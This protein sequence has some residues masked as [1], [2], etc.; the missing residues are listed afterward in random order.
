MTATPASGPRYHALDALR[1]TM[2]LLGIYLHAAVAYA[3]DGGW[4]WKQ[5]DL[6][7]LLEPSMA[8]IHVFRMPLFYVMAGFFAA[9]LVERR[10]AGKAAANRAWRILLPFVLGWAVVFPMVALLVLIGRVGVAGGFERFATGRFFAYAA[11]LHLWFLEYL[12]VLYAL[13]GL[14]LPLARL[15]PAGVRHPAN[16]IFRA[17]TAAWWG[18][19][20]LAVPSFLAL[21]A[22]PRAELQDP[23]GFMPVGHIVVAYAIPFAFGWMLYGNADLLDTIRRRGW[24][25]LAAALVPLVL[26]LGFIHLP[27]PGHWFFY[28]RRIEHSLALWLLVFGTTGVFLRVV[29]RHD[30]R[31]RYLC[32]SSYFLY[33]A[34]MPVLLALQLAL[35]AL[36]LH[37]AIKAM[38]ALAA[39]TVLLLVVYHWAVRPTAI[40]ALLNG[41]RIPH[42]RPPRPLAPARAP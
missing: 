39:A 9:L 42:T 38:M 35:V 21:L 1:G 24:I 16:R 6:T 3:P 15:A 33:I 37:P 40:G 23:P 12:L 2:M 5:A 17:V 20:A 26:F 18:P 36:P 30:A 31:L 14:A 27:L 7:R 11:P 19:A 4:P 25:N 8:A 29:D 22:M 28:V 10:G 41:R 13:A 34:H 32:D